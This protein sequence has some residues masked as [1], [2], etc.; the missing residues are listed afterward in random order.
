MGAAPS[1]GL[2]LA[3]L[4]GFGL[5]AAVLLRRPGIPA[6]A[7]APALQASSWVKQD[8][9][10]PF[11]VVQTQLPNLLRATR[12]VKCNELTECLERLQE[13]LAIHDWR[14]LHERPVEKF[15]TWLANACSSG[16]VWEEVLAVTSARD[17]IRARLKDIE[18]PKWDVAPSADA[19]AQEANEL[20]RSAAGRGAPKIEKSKRLWKDDD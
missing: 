1:K 17:A 10:D 14:A 9:E 19:E 13:R 3:S 4:A 15:A 6:A 5:A 20:A 8:D 16:K 2:I 18:D 11:D 7:A 12:T